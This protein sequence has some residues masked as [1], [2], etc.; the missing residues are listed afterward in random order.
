M[1]C[2][3]AHHARWPLLTSACVGAAMQTPFS[4]RL[5]MSRFLL[6]CLVLLSVLCVS[7]AQFSVTTIRSI[8]QCTECASP[9]LDQMVPIYPDLSNEGLLMSDIGPMAAAACAGPYKFQSIGTGGTNGFVFNNTDPAALVLMD[10]MILYDTTLQPSQQEQEA[11]EEEEDWKLMQRPE[12]QMHTKRMFQRSSTLARWAA[13]QPPQQAPQ[14]F[15][16]PDNSCTFSRYVPCTLVLQLDCLYTA[17]SIVQYM[18]VQLT[19]SMRVSE[20]V[21]MLSA[22]CG[23]VWPNVTIVIDST[24]RYTADNKRLAADVFRSQDYVINGAL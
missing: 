22:R 10:S 20:V 19:P 11:E 14:P 17:N 3:E 6:L 7:R 13:P 9:C 8:L 5:A 4:P 2:G 23:A 18:P 21:A 15:F 1:G 12:E 24:T 16:A